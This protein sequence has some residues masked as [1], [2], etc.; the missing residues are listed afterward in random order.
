MI[1]KDAPRMID[2]LCPECEKHFGDLKNC[3]DAIGVKYQIDTSIVRGLDYYTKT[4]F[5]IISEKQGLTICGG[6]RYDK[7]IDICGGPDLPGV[8]FGMG[9]ERLISVIEDEGVEI[10]KPSE[11]DVYVICINDSIRSFTISETLRKLG[12]KTSFDH[13]SRSIKNQMRQAEKYG[14]RFAVIEGEDEKEKGIVAVKDMKE[15]SQNE[16]PFISLQDY[17]IRKL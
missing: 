6:G 17:L 13:M 2:S 9:L 14:A 15:G 10:Q 8:G 3:L 7:L 4:V 1:A 5:E 12:I 16:I 11:C